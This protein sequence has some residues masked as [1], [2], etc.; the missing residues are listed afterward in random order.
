M[1]KKLIEEIKKVAARAEECVADI[2]VIESCKR[3]IANASKKLSSCNTGNDLLPEHL[4]NEVIRVGCEAVKKQR[5]DELRNMTIPGLSQ[6]IKPQY[7]DDPVTL[8][9]AEHGQPATMEIG[10]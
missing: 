9:T 6:Y 8:C 4:L 7:H 2:E 5:E 3:E 1:D 10:H